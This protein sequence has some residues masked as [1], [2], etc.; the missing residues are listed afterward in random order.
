V[1]FESWR[2]LDGDRAAAVA[3]PPDFE[4]WLEGLRASAESS[5]RKPASSASGL[6]GTDPDAS[7]SPSGELEV[8][9]L[10][11]VGDRIG[12]EAVAAGVAKGARDVE[13]PA[14]A[15]GRYGSAVGRAV[16]G[17]LQSVDL[18]TGAGLDEAVAAQ[19]VAEGVVEFSGLVTALVASA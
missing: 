11:Q 7:T 17:V 13:Q 4:R 6:E 5:R 3:P 2:R 8:A 9:G 18:A 15:K 16:H 14:W 19:C 10:E 1:S 12:A